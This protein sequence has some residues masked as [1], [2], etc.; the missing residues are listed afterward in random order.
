MNGYSFGIVMQDNC[1]HYT[2]TVPSDIAP[3]NY[4]IRAEVI[5]QSSSPF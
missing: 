3:G 5:G 4:L 2:F 1:G